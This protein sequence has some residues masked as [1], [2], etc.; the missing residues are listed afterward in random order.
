MTWRAIAAAGLAVAPLVAGGCSGDSGPPADAKE[1]KAA[2]L[3]PGSTTRVSVADDGGEANGPSADASASATG[4][5]IAFVSSASNLVPDDTNGAPDVFVRDLR[6]G[7]TERVSVTS[8]GGEA[9]GASCCTQVSATGRLVLFRSLASNLVEGDRN[10]VFDVFLHD[11]ETGRTERVSVGDANQEGTA[12]SGG[13]YMSAGGRV[14]ASASDS[15]NL[16]R[17]DTNG[18]MDAFVRDRVAHTTERAS[19]S[20]TGEQGNDESHSSSMSADGRYVAF[21]SHAT[22]LVRGD[23]N[24]HGD[25]FVRDRRT[26]R[27]ERVN[28]SSEGT[29]ANGPT[30]RATLDASGRFVAFRSRASNLVRGDTNGGL[31]VFVRDRARRRTERVSVDSRGRQVFGLMHRPF[32][33]GNGRYVVFRSAARRLVARDTNGVE[34]IFLHDRRTRRTIRVSVGPNGRQGNGRSG[35]PAVSRDGRLVVFSSAASNL[36]AGDRNGASDVFVHVPRW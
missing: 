18:V 16:V 27:V 26:G 10:G 14:V 7:T 34:D 12:Q 9:R 33:S 1:P 30:F 35:R 25:D 5:V 32:L 17:G 6:A 19:V 11:R 8:R 36:V 4:A 28:V 22:N 3:S 13:A 23:T 24:G 15:P 21:R 20:G 31:D 2:Q 29:Q